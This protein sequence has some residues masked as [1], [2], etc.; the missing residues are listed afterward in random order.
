M[1]QPISDDPQ[2]D[3]ALIG[4]FTFRKAQDFLDGVNSLYENDGKFNGEFYA[5]SVIQELVNMGKKVKV[6]EVDYYVSWGTPNDFKTYEYWQSFFHKCNWHPYSM[7]S[8]VSNQL[9]LKS[10]DDRYRKMKND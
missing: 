3:H 8:H 5:D 9:K 1:K 6:F 7:E 4:T 2:K 10:L